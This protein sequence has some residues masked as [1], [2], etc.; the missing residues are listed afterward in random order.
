M[1]VQIEFD[2]ETDGLCPEDR[3]IFEEMVQ[4]QVR[5][6]LLSLHP[7]QPC[8]SNEARYRYGMPEIIITGDSN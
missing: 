7:G 8:I 3:F 1:K 5:S 2:V 6:S 4:L